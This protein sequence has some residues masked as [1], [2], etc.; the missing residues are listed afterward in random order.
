MLIN[1]PEEDPTRFLSWP[2]VPPQPAPSE[3]TM[4]LGIFS[5]SKEKEQRHYIRE[6]MLNVNDTRVCPLYVYIDSSSTVDATSFD[7]SR[8]QVLYAFIVGADTDPEAPTKNTHAQNLT[9]LVFPSDTEEPDVVRLT[10]K[11]NMNAGKS[12][13]YFKYGALLDQEL[14]QTTTHTTDEETH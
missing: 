1:F 7:T 14:Q 5:M 12:P 11:E 4:L 8:C 10:I 2:M 3:S 13:T 6:T 9:E